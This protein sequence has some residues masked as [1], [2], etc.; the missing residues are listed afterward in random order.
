MEI[1][2]RLT[3][4]AM[5]VGWVTAARGRWRTVEGVGGAGAVKVSG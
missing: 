4:L 2:L 5:G 1:E 3:R